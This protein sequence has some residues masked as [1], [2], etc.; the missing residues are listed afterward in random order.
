MF[1][2][3]HSCLLLAQSI[4]LL[5]NVSNSIYFDQKENLNLHRFI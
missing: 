4:Q 3:V 5:G 2:S 1:H